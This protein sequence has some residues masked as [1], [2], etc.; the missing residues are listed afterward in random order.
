MLSY[1]YIYILL[2][3]WLYPVFNPVLIVYESQEK[4]KANCSLVLM[5]LALALISELPTDFLLP[6]YSVV[7][8]V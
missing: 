7:K 6:N 8:P 1:E 5:T 4:D 2:F 3:K